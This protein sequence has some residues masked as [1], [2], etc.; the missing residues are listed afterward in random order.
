MEIEVGGRRSHNPLPENIGLLERRPLKCLIICGVRRVSTE[1]GEAVMEQWAEVYSKQDHDYILPNLGRRSRGRPQAG[2][3]EG[4]VFHHPAFHILEK[5]RQRSRGDAA[6]LHE[7]R[8]FVEN[9][10]QPVGTYPTKTHP[11]PPGAAEPPT[12]KSVLMFWRRQSDSSG[13]KKATPDARHRSRAE[14]AD[15]QFEVTIR[16][17]LE[18]E[19]DQSIPVFHFMARYS[20]DGPGHNGPG[21]LVSSRIM[22]RPAADRA[23]RDPPQFEVTDAVEI[24][25]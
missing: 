14:P 9:N 1:S 2:G 20:G 6:I 19:G 25:K 10:R 13:K 8:T 23:F 11:E 21:D 24:E 4:R 16:K 5:D 18:R 12:P 17:V 3:S 15:K 22:K 7:L